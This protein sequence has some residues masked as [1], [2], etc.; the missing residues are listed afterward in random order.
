MSCDAASTPVHQLG[1]SCYTLPERAAFRIAVRFT[2]LRGVSEIESALLTDHRVM[3]GGS[4]HH[5]IMID[6][7]FSPIIA[8]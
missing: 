1:K 6:A 7:H 3:I 8:S 4:H 5:E 2:S